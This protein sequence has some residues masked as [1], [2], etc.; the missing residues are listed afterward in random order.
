MTSL[1]VGPKRN[2]SL[3]IKQLAITDTYE[4]YYWYLLGGGANM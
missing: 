1:Q 2:K 4:Y 3:T